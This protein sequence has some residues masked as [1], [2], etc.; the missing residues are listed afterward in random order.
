MH[1]GIYVITP[2]EL[3][4]EGKSLSEGE[5]DVTVWMVALNRYFQEMQ[6]NP[7]LMQKAD[8]NKQMIKD[9]HSGN[10]QFRFFEIITGAK[11]SR[12]NLFNDTRLQVG[13][14]YGKNDITITDMKDLVS[15]QKGAAIICIGGHAMSVV[16][17][18]D[19]KLLIQE[20]NN[21]TSFSEEIYD[22]ENNHILFIKTDDINGNPTYE[23]TEY[24]FEHYN[25]GE[26]VIKWE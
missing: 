20:S 9:I 5:G 26:G 23:L 17:I 18:K 15:N 1:G 2:E 12:Q 22:S 3:E 13:V 4:A 8:D 10:A 7:E 21:S 6:Q 16:G 11:A 25:F 19:N 14:S 24:D